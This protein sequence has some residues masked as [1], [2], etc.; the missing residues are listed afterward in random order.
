MPPGRY[1]GLRIGFDLDNTLISYD[2]LFFEAAVRS[3][4][5]PP[6]FRGTKRDIRDRIRLLPDGELEW[7]RLQAD[8]YGYGVARAVPASGA[9]EFAKRARAGGAE[10]AIVSHKSVFANIGSADVNLRDAAR[11]WLR[12]SGLLGAETIP[13]ENL[14]FESTRNEK[15]ARIIAFGCTHFIDDLEEV[16]NDPSFPEGVERMLLST[17]RAVPAG[18]YRAYAS[19]HEIADAFAD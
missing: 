10:L 13:E 5:V 1:S 8:V 12:K 6:D 16:F 17:I 11:E 4:F 18:P 7:Q 9:L 14:F 15:I 3:Q 19:F 2:G